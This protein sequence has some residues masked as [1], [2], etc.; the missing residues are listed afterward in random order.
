M[1]QTKRFHTI[2]LAFLLLSTL[3]TLNFVGGAA[4]AQTDLYVDA[5]AGDNKT[6]DGT[7]A[8]PYK[9]ITFALAISAKNNKPDPWRV[10]IQSF[11]KS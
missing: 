6:G 5:A 11:E 8:K 7:A 9:S 4:N 2:T 3:L 1:F 10:H